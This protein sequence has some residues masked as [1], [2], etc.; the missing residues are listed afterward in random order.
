MAFGLYNKIKSI[1]AVLALGLLSVSCSQK[2]E[3]GEEVGY[4]CFPAFSIDIAIEDIVETKA[5][6]LYNTPDV[7]DITFVVTDAK[8][9]TQTVNG[10]WSSAMVLPV[11]AY[12]IDATYGS[13]SLGVP[14]LKGSVS[15]TIRGFQEETPSLKM[16]L[17]N[18]MIKVSVGPTL[19]GH[20]I[21]S[22]KVTIGTAEANY[23]EWYYVPSGSVVNIV[24]TGTNS[25]GN[26]TEFTHSITPVSGNAYNV[27]CEQHSTNWPSITIPEQQAGA[28]G[29]KLYITPGFTVTNGAEPAEEIEY[30]VTSD[31]WATV[32]TSKAVDGYHV[33]E[34]L[35]NGSTYK[36]RGKVGLIY[37][38]EVFVTV[39]TPNISVEA[40]HYTTDG[41]L[42]GTN[43]NV[44]VE[45]PEGILQELNSKNLLSV[46]ASL[47][48]GSAQVR[49]L[50]ALSGTMTEASDW[51]YLPQGSDYT[52]TINHKIK[53]EAS[54]TSSVTALDITL[55]LPTFTVNMGNESYSSYDKYKANDKDGANACNA[56]TIYAA[57]AS[58]TIS[59]KLMSNSNYTKSV[60]LYVDDVEKHS[61]VPTT[62]SISGVNFSGLTTWKEYKIKASMTFDGVTVEST[63]Q[64]SHHITGLPYTAAPPKN[65]GEHLWTSNYQNGLN[66]VKW[67]TD[68]VFLDAVSKAPSITSPEFN[69][70]DDINVYVESK[71]VLNALSWW[72]FGT[73]WQTT[74]YK[75]SIG[76][77]TFISQNSG[78]QEDNKEFNVNGTSKFTTANKKL[79][80]LSDYAATGP[81]AKI[82]TIVIKYN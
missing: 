57:G 7:S 46:S 36:V 35:S 81:N 19:A 30:E 23:N 27:V 82:Y 45:I 74:N 13:N 16:S 68:H 48:K 77:D 8:G 64:K 52:S 41:S 26:S 70:L 42:A 51:P 53:S 62:P 11:G 28:W 31:D 76:D 24:L 69:I 18:A 15:G 71:V 56:E 1:L 55:P 58:W 32:K 49:T 10:A 78:E 61:A 21:P 2:E 67:Q 79:V 43:A 22:E 37:S 40:T 33:V 73:Q 34:G 29:N 50:T 47:L 5:V 72:F 12:T 63:T 66:S 4:L 39:A 3:F 9:S 60:K 38:N 80:C 65:T 14:Y 17:Q 25:F 59:S 44:T 54:A 20:F 75:V 6:D